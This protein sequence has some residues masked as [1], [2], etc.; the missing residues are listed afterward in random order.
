MLNKLFTSVIIPIVL[1]CIACI[2]LIVSNPLPAYAATAEIEVQITKVYNKA[3]PNDPA[4]TCVVA[5]VVKNN[6]ITQ[7]VVLR[8]DVR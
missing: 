6:Q 7:A 4:K 1:S 3:C 5:D 2:S 8:E